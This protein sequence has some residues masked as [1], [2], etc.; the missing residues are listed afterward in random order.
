[1]LELPCG[2]QHVCEDA[3]HLEVLHP[4]TLRPQI[5]GQP[6][7]AVVTNLLN[8]AMPFIRYVQGDYVTRPASPAP[9]LIGWSQLADIGGRVNDS[10]LNLRGQVTPAGTILD[11]VYRWMFDAGLPIREFELVQTAPDMIRATFIPD[12][13]ATEARIQVSVGHLR[14]LLAV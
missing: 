12:A 9:C 5:A 11:V 8:E 7:L 13:A 4:D 2:H 10:F 6:G 3:V 1:S 14:D